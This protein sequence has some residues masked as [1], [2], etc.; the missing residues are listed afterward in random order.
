MA[1]A[2]ALHSELLPIETA[3]CYRTNW[4]L[5]SPVQEIDVFFTFHLGSLIEII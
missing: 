2:G 4:T 5:N 1:L 3:F